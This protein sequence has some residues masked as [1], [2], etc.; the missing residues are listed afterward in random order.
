MILH[1]ELHLK[2]DPSLNVEFICHMDSLLTQ[3]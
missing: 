3:T 2:E 1:N